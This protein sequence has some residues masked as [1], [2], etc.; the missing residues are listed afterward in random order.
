MV[1]RNLS[2]DFLI[3]LLKKS[4]FDLLKTIDVAET[5]GFVCRRNVPDEPSYIVIAFRGTEKKF[6]DWLTD[7]RAIPT[8]MGKTK[9]HTG[10]MEAFSVITDQDGQTVEDRVKSIINAP[11][12]KDG[13]GKPLPLFITGHSLGGALALLATKL[14]AS[15]INGACYT[16]GAPRLANYEY[17]AKLKTP[18]YR[19]VNSS[20]IVP[21]V[22]PGAANIV[23]VG[24]AKLFAWSTGFIPAISAQFNKLEILLDKLNGYRHYGDLRYLTDVA[25][26]RFSD[27]KMLR[28]PPAIDR[29]IWF[30]RHLA[31]SLYLPLNNHSMSVYRKKLYQVA[32][33]RNR[34]E[35]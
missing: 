14:L 18:V 15:N 6:S 34:K 22:P 16:F 25:D 32:N 20:D 35:E 12:V 7:A 26:G 33:N 8:S 3:D 30:W 1:S 4:G 27:V 17:F 11:E 23:F 28:N 31:T 29:A 9:V 5:Q 2:D 19:I 24:L 21:R 10:F 13:D